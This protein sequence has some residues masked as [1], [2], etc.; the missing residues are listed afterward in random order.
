MPA[1]GMV[2]VSDPASLTKGGGRPGEPGFPRTKKKPRLRLR[3]LLVFALF[4]EATA[5]R[6]WLCGPATSFGPFVAVSG[7]PLTSHKPGVR[8]GA[9][10]TEYRPVRCG[11][12]VAR[13]SDFQF[14]QFTTFV[15]LL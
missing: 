9:R 12:Q 1:A 13:S 7:A 3:G 2:S 6:P 5:R 11:R 8:L 10:W 14:R 15:A 4:G